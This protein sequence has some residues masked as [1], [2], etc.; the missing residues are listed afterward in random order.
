MKT[1]HKISIL[2]IIVLGLFFTISCSKSNSESKL[3]G[4]WKNVRVENINDTTRI[5]DWEFLADGKLII[6]YRS[7]EWGGNPD[8]IQT[9]KYEANYSMDSYNK[10][11]IAGLQNG[12]LPQYNT[13]WEI[14]FNKD[15]ALMV[16]N[17]GG[18]GLFFREFVK[19]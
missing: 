16:V 19:E 11:S 3:I 8:T 18:G 6:Y 10:F 15:N 9:K 12:H 2:S 13:Q 4:K 17:E 5:E 1:I 7:Y 14:I